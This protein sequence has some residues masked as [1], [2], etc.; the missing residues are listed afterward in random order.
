MAQKEK[1]DSFCFRKEM[2]QLLLLC[3]SQLELS[4]KQ[5]DVDILTLSQVFQDLIKIC[6]QLNDE[7][8]T[9]NKLNALHESLRDSVN[10]GVMAFQFYDRLMQ[11]LDH[12]HHNIDNLIEIVQERE[13]LDNEEKWSAIRADLRDCYS[14]SS[15]R[16]VFEAI[17]SGKTKQQALDINLKAEEQA[18]DDIELF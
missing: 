15:E 5:S 8:E 2:A 18:N 17:M 3:T 16:K 14:M 7:N 13:S 9:S 12:I 4:K 1:H 10:N 11:Q 6:A